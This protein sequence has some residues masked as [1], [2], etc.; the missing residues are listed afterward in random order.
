MRRNVTQGQIH[1]L[2]FQPLVEVNG[3]D[4]YTS[5]LYTIHLSDACVPVCV[6]CV[7]VSPWSCGS[8]WCPG[9]SQVCV[10]P[11]T[12][13]KET[14]PG[15]LSHSCM[16]NQCSPSTTR[17]HRERER[18]ERERASESHTRREEREHERWPHITAGKSMDAH[19]ESRDR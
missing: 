1:I 4:R 19:A 6:S 18:E 3:G 9:L 8:V 10:A 12:P 5:T 13:H 14:L 15:P 2:L 11:W 17:A 16:T 7:S